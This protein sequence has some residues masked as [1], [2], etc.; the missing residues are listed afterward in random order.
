MIYQQ[1]TGNILP[2]FAT[3]TEQMRYREN[4]TSK[5]GLIT[6][7]TA[8]LPFQFAFDI[9]IGAYSW[10]LIDICDETTST[11][12]DNSY[13]TEECADGPGPYF[14][15][16]DGSVITEEDFDC[17]YYY[18]KLTVNTVEYFSEVMH[19]K[20]LCDKDYSELAVTA[21]SHPVA[22]VGG[23][24]VEFTVTHTVKAAKGVTSSSVEYYR[25]ASWNTGT[26]FAILDT[27]ETVDVRTTLVTP[28]G[29][30]TKTYEIVWDNAD[31]CGTYVMTETTSD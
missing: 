14:L 20:E 24:G 16:Y 8:L 25:G 21:C 1:N 27:D 26:T 23:D 6:P 15:T 30:I 2:F 5:W 29:T 3:V 9:P 22:V 17:G 11:V 10:E 4:L 13:L 31:P 12:L 28:C 18:I 19:L 7:R